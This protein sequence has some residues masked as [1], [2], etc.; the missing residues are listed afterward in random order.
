[1]AASWL[2]VFSLAASAVPPVAE[3]AVTPASAPACSA[4]EHRQFDFWA[5]DWVVTRPDTGAELGRNTIS[6][7]AGACLLREHWRGGSGFEG[8]S[9]NA[10]DRRRGAWMQVWVG[11]DG[12][13]LRLEGGLRDGA[14]VLEGELPQASGGVQRQ[15]ITWT[16][17]ADGSVTQ[18]WQVSDDDGGS[19]RT[20]FLGVYRRAG[21]AGE[22]DQA[23]GEPGSGEGAPKP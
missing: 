15:R 23:R 21:A 9:L 14:M 7:A 5:G 2:L 1:M 10:Y 4:T 12:V 3:P 18:H 11:A 8:H 22:A 6:H 20:S 13:V 17:A 19:W 16:P